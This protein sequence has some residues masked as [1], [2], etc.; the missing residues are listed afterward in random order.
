MEVKIRD[1]INTK[2]QE[3]YGSDLWEEAVPSDIRVVVEQRIESQVKAHPYEL[4]KYSSLEGKLNFLDIMDYSK[5]I[6]SNWNIFAGIFSSKGELEKHFLALKHYRNGV[7]HSR[8][9]NPVVQKN[10]EASVLWFESVLS[11]K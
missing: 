2:L 4:E 9:M 8:D 6:L 11:S 3:N 1:L 5:I 10:G 7:K